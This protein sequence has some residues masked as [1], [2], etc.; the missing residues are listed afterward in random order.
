MTPIRPNPS[1][2]RAA[3]SYTGNAL[4]NALAFSAN[5]SGNRA[6]GVLFLQ[7]IE[8]PPIPQ[9][10]GWTVLRAFASLSRT[11]RGAI[12]DKVRNVLNATGKTNP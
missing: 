4:A 11:K 7:P 6:T 10:F 8:P 5:S 2:D 12:D 1:T 3:G 9:F